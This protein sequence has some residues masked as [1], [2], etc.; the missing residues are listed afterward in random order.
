[1]IAFG[2]VSFGSGYL[3]HVFEGAW[4]T[5]ALKPIWRPMDYIQKW[6]P[7]AITVHS[8]IFVALFL[9][10]G[11]AL[12]CCKCDFMRGAKFGFKIWLIAAFANSFCWFI[13]ENITMDVV[14]LGL[15]AQF[16]AYVIGGAIVG[17]IIG[18]PA[19]A[20]EAASCNTEKTACATE[21]PAGSCSTGKNGCGGKNHC[22]SKA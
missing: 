15:G 14:V 12:Q 19:C 4:N 2:L 3:W 1:M 21:K 7:L 18:N 9:C 6:M 13:T 22:G 8:I 11:K 5:P 10:L 16:L 20:G 17:K